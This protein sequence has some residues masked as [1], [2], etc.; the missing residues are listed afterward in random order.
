MV[1]YPAQI[2][3]ST[4]IPI[5]TDNNTLVKASV[6][7]TLREA[8]LAIE[9]ELGVKPGGTSTVKDRL[10]SIDATITNLQS[11]SLSGDLGGS[12]ATP[13]VKG[14]QGKLVSNQSPQLNEVLTWNGLA[15][16]PAASGSSPYGSNTQIQFNDNGLFGASSVLTFNKNTR[17]LSITDSYGTT[18]LNS[19]KLVNNTA[20]RSQSLT[21][22]KEVITYD[23]TI[24]DLYSWTINDNSTTLVDVS[25]T[26]INLAGTISDAWKETILF[27]RYNGTV[28]VD[29]ALSTTHIGASSWSAILDNSTSTGRIRVTGAISNSIYWT[30]V[31]KLQTSIII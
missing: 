12:A 24:T 8:I 31:I 25:I 27:R 16:V 28:T 2:D 29:A 26:A 13:L 3:N 9:S 6:T 22:L 14:I 1:K 20:L 19:T 30:A 15:W 4:S 23:N 10:T 11:I 5:S 17:T 21:E 7:N 18:T